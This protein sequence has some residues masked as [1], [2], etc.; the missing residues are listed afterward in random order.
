M[1]VATT[2]LAASARTAAN[3]AALAMLAR[4]E[5]DLQKEIGARLGA[6][7]NMLALPPEERDEKTGKETEHSFNGAMQRAG[8]RPVGAITGARFVGA[9]G[10]SAWFGLGCQPATANEAL[11]SPRWNS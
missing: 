8:T 2:I 1:I 11:H 7:T 6:L 5:Q 10:R 4:R 3:D 9:S